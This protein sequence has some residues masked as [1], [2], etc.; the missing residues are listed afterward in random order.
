MGEPMKLSELSGEI[1][2]LYKSDYSLVHTLEYFDCTVKQGWEFFEG[3]GYASKNEPGI[4]RRL[5]CSQI[6]SGVPMRLF[7]DSSAT[8]TGLLFD[9]RDVDFIYTAPNIVHNSIRNTGQVNIRNGSVFD[10]TDKLQKIKVR[11]GYIL[12]YD[13]NENK[14]QACLRA[15]EKSWELIKADLPGYYNETRD[16]DLINPMVTESIVNMNEVKDIKAIIVYSSTPEINSHNRDYYS[17]RSLLEAIMMKGFLIEKYNHDVPVVFY[18]KISRNDFALPDVAEI[19]I[20][21]KKVLEAINKSD[22]MYQQNL[23]KYCDLAV[24]GFFADH[25]LP[26]FKISMDRSV[27][28]PDSLIMLNDFKQMF[29]NMVKYLGF[30]G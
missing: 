3:Y 24:G 8:A 22:V 15:I 14:N 25:S 10:I 13:I 30:S 12:P 21:K 26:K 9:A 17:D 4:F 23:M 5:P 27:S 20:D 18:Q 6:K 16:I 2:R 7:S 19:E 29:K 11:N 1:A 28:Q